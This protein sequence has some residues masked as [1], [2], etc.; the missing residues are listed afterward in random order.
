MMSDKRK[1]FLSLLLGNTDLALT[2]ALFGVVILLVLPVAP[3]FMDLL[4]AGSIG[5]SLLVLLIVIYVRDPA[6]FNV[7]PTM[8][9][10]VTLFR[11]GLNVASTRL[12][13]LDGFAGN[14]IQSFGN[15]VVKGNFVVG[16]VVFCIL[17][18]IN[19]VVI[20]KGAGRIAEVAARFT[21]DAMPG[22]QMSIDAEMNAGLIDEAEATRRRLKIQKEAD[23]YGAMDG[24][25]K[26]VRGDA[27]AGILI[28][29]I[30]IVGGIAIGAWQKGLPLM[31]AMEKYTL[32]SIGDGLVSQIPA[33]I[34]S[35][36]A[37]IL[38]TRTSDDS[39]LGTHL[40]KQ[41]SIYPRAMGVAAVMLAIFGILPG[42]PLLPFTLLAAAC[43]TTAYFLNRRAKETAREQADN[44]AIRARREAEGE[45][46]ETAAPKPGSQADLRGMI[47][48][49]PF[50]IELGYNLLTLAD[51]KTGGDLLDRIT[52]VRQ[53]FAREMGLV[54]PPVAVRD[55]LELDAAEYRFLVRNK[56]L[57]RGSL[58]PGRWLAMNVTGS[59]VA[60]KGV[61]TVEPVFGIEAF[62][63]DDNERKNAEVNGF[64]V[65]DA[66]S[67]LIT[68][69]AEV[70]RDSAAV[71][72]EREDVQKLVD[73]VKDKNPTLISELLPDLVT[74]GLIQRVLQN[75]LAERVPIKNL[76]QILETVSDFASY[77]KNPDDLSEQVR[78]RI[79]GWFV[80]QLAG[81]DGQLHA[82][83]LEPRLEQLLV[84]RVKRNQFEI[85]LL[86][87]P[88]LTEYLIGEL[89]PRLNALTEQGMEPILITTTELRLAIRR[90]F[91]PSF[92]RMTVL[93]Y[94]EIPNETRIE[95][96]GMITMPQEMLQNL[97][98][99]PAPAAAAPEQQPAA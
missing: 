37:G 50:A 71:L 44:E 92:P 2:F 59:T 66:S 13:L 73:V 80:P 39:N 21:L 40:G 99:Q 61:P 27:V 20:T 45:E 16:I 11:L 30:N 34:V 75:L 22:K 42:M 57:A 67:V 72:L 32:L 46:D 55:N 97:Q 3:G 70:L 19:F 68:H 15:F 28:T 41:L 49:D 88:A 93:A 69:L 78:K 24:A 48:T 12:I 51:R 23:F 84:S 58:T 29:L 85:G 65:V 14:V 62:W 10:A 76:T 31:E 81:P 9:L 96:A 6:E 5:L 83:T 35:V 25:S 77:T 60:L 64:T 56:E 38:I 4:L 87:D 17:V 94:Q 33:L 7:F 52:G 98:Q 90:F 79:G 82:H 43:G 53:K 1:S 74:V 95:N 89:T 63:I 8:L 86:M 36:G 18:V 47:G 54:V 91:E 26:F